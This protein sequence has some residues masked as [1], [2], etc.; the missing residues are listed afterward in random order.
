MLAPKEISFTT[1]RGGDYLIGKPHVN[2]ALVTDPEFFI[3]AWNPGRL[4]KE[5]E[6]KTFE[7]F[8]DPKWVKRLIAEAFAGLGEIQVPQRGKGVEVFMAAS[9]N[10]FV[11]LSGQ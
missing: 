3:A 4:K 11:T 1:F 7:D 8:A 10:C 6:P 2:L 5:Y 9:T